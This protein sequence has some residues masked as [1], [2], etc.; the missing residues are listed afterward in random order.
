M[1][2]KFYYYPHK[3]FVTTQR[4]GN[5]NP[6]YTQLGFTRHNG[7]DSNVGK[8]DWSGKV[9]SEYPVYCPV[10][11]Y[12]VTE[13]AYFPQGGG[14]QIGMVSKDKQHIGDQLCYVSIILCHAKKVL[15]KVGDEPTVGELLMIADNTGFSTGVHTHTGM[16]RLDDN[17]QKLD[18]N[19]MT[20]SYDPSLLFTGEYAVDVAS[21]GTLVK[22]G[23]RYY[24]YLLGV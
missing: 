12:K 3:P 18:Q 20:G 17:L 1:P 7:H 10:E 15:V 6:S 2:L 11:N 8:F 13:V 24:R 21:Y 14:N 5:F 23:W 19:E 9:V 22:S 16:Y 4:W